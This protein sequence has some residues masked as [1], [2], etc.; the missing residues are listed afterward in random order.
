MRTEVDTAVDIALL[1]QGQRHI[2]EKMT[3]FHDET[4]AGFAAIN[5]KFDAVLTEL[6]EQRS[7]SK[8][9]NAMWA[10]ARHL[11]TVIVTLFLA[12]KLHVPVDF[13]PGN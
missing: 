7:S 2:E 12:K 1:Q 3:S 6:Q 11:A 4:R 8:M 9:R 10:T 13:G 5:E